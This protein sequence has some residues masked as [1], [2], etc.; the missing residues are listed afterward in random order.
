MKPAIMALALAMSLGS[1]AAF[2]QD[3]PAFVFTAIPDQDETR[4]VERFTRVAE[5]LQGKL[6]VPVEFVAYASSGEII[7]AM[8]SGAWDVTFMPV[9]DQRKQVLDFAAP[10]HLLQ[11]TYLVAPGSTIQTLA[12]V[13]R[14]GVRIAGVANTATFR[15]SNRASTSCPSRATTARCVR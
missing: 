12:E 5:Y 15:A 9:D 7:A 3:K 4:L 10:Y 1:G 6:G 14:A 13:N 11:S 2:A 8:N